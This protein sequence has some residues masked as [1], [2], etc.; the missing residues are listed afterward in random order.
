MNNIFLSAAILASI[1]LI[2]VWKYPITRKYLEDMRRQGTA[3]K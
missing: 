3:D 1:A 2:P